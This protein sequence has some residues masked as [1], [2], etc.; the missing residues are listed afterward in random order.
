MVEV[1]NHGFKA[2]QGEDDERRGIERSGECRRVKG[3]G[4][5]VRLKKWYS[6]DK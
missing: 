5:G 3:L 1:I 4:V 6:A 2:A